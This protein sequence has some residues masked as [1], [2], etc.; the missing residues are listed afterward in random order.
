MSDSHHDYSALDRPEVRM[1]LFYPR[2]EEFRAV[3]KDNVIN[4]LIPV[5]DNVVIGSTFHSTGKTNPTILFFHGNGEIVA[6]Y[7]DLAPIYNNLGINFLIVDYRGYGR[8]TGVPSVSAMMSD[9]H[10]IMEFVTQWLSDH[11]F[12][13]PFVVMGRSLGSASALE[14]AATY[15]D[16]IDGI[17]IESGF[18]Y[19][20]PLLQLMGI[21]V[22]L[23]GIS[24]E[25][26][27]RNLEKIRLFEKPVLIIHAEYDHIIPFSDGQAL[28]DASIT[29]DKTF[30][31]IDGANH[32][33][34]M[35][36]GFKIYM[37]GIHDFIGKLQ[38]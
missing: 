8:S 17:I 3:P 5:E 36:R 25:D 7:D 4:I 34:I 30:I 29:S 27:C 23:L 32:N 33:D 12:T 24:E 2:Q 38:K 1:F 19:L 13:G 26:G 9:C 15:Q 16:K 28:F 10:T 31:K 22:R 18:A 35:F 21:N 14:L 20:L 11:E 6:D 37:Q